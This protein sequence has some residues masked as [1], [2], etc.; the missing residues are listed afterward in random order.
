MYTHL[1]ENVGY[2]KMNRSN[3]TFVDLPYELLFIILKKLDNMNVLYSLLDVDNQ[4]LDRLVKE[5]TFTR[6]LNF[7]IT[8][9][10]KDILSIADSMLDRF[11]VNILPK[12]DYNVKCLILETGSLERIL[13]AATFPNL[14][15][16]KFF[17]CNEKIVSRYFT[18]KKILL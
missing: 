12:I 2:N 17:N 11:C 13:R 4:R 15:E 5:E 8:T 9:S 6:T 1:K 10:T 7:V 16:L 3:L 14:T 18:G